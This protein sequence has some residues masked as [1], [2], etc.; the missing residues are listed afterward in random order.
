MRYLVIVLTLIGGAAVAQEP[1]PLDPAGYFP[2]AVGNE[3][4]YAFDLDRPASPARPESESRT[5]YVRLR[6]VADGLGPEGGRFALVSERFSDVG[7]LLSRDT[8]GVAFDPETA[9][10]RAFG[11][12]TAYP[13]DPSDFAFDL[14][15]PLG[16]YAPDSSDFWHGASRIPEGAI[17]DTLPP[18]L[19]GVDPAET[20]AFESLMHGVRAVHG[21]GL[22]GGWFS[23]DG[24]SSFC[25]EDTWILTYAEVDGV[26]YGARAV[27]VEAPPVARA[28][29][30]LDVSPNPSR[31]WVRVGGEGARVDVFDALGRRVLTHATLPHEPAR[32]SVSMLPPGVYVVHRGGASGV[33]TVQ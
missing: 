28:A 21:L 1:D 30:S 10:V 15:Y 13:Y 24:C 8:T 16:G 7:D 23:P 29:A 3:W 22:V 6:V 5:E 18:F 12:W 25:D 17:D 2:L 4:E 31:S 32:M 33:V 14:D 27:G 26:T 20:K 9:S 19:S 11:G